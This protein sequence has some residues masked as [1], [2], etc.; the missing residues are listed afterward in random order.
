MKFDAR[1]TGWK[2]GTLETPAVRGGK[3]VVGLRAWGWMA[4][5]WLAGWLTFCTF[6]TFGVGV[7]GSVWRRGS[8]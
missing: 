3:G 8:K 5:S 7:I 6:G 1:Y 4:G 2:M